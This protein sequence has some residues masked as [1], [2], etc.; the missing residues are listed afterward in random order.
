MKPYHISIDGKAVPYAPG[1]TIMEA[2]ATAD[3]YIPHL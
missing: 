1:Q 3:V 2:A